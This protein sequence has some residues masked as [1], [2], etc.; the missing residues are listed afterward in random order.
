MEEPTLPQNTASK[1]TL[2]VDFFSQ[3]LV[4]MFEIVFIKHLLMYILEFIQGYFRK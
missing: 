4:Q 1:I 3:F 2:H